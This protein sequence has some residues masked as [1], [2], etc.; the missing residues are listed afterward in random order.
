MFQ[1][2]QFQPQ[3]WIR[4]AHLQTML[5]TI[6]RRNLT[7]PTI[8]ERLELEDGDFLDLAWTALPT[9]ES[10]KPIVIIFHGLEGSVESP[11]V[12]GIMRAVS[13]TGWIGLVM[14][15]RGCS[16]ESNRLLRAYHSGDTSDASY[17]IGLIAKRYPHAP[18]FAVGYSLGGSVLTHYLA[19]TGKQSQLLA[20]SVVSAPLLLAE[21]AER[22]KKGFSKAYQRRLI[23]RLQASVVRKFEHLDMRTALN[24]TTKQVKKLNTF[25]E[26]DDRVTAPLHGFKD[27]LDYY[28]QCSSLQFLHKIQTPTLF[29][30]AEDDPFL[31]KKVIPELKDMSANILFELS[32][33]GGHVGF[34]YGSILK[35]KYWLE[36][37]IPAWFS[38]FTKDKNSI[39]DK[40]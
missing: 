19:Q 13:A 1:P 6:S 39:K 26:F 36:E 37:R 2:S 35:P 18:L 9:V 34:V 3:W 24:L 12:K 25:V 20:A 32:R 4:N 14:H 7:F 30:H 38:E 10:N 27:A 16:E 22:I 23:K 29:I 17:V 11:Y 8:N 40:K 21:S 31:T 15:F 28:R 5:P 33:Y